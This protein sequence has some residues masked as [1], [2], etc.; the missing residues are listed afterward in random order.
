MNLEGAFQQSW[1]DILNEAESNA[2]R[3]V[4]FFEEQLSNLSADRFDNDKWESMVNY[5]QSV[6]KSLSLDAKQLLG[7]IRHIVQ[8]T[9]MLPNAPSPIF[10]EDEV[11]E[12]I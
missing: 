7:Q 9:Q 12:S 4:A 3:N 8:G 11:K 2:D 6:Q 10:T 5:I 1:I